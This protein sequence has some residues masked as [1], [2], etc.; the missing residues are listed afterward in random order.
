MYPLKYHLH[1][2]MIDDL[3]HAAI[4]E[5]NTC[6]DLSKLDGIHRYYKFEF[7]SIENHI[8]LCD[9]VVKCDELLD[10]IKNY[11][12]EINHMVLTLKRW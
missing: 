9:N 8:K 12:N 5:I 11:R 4:N 1:K 10:M 7:E 2:R 3:L 6:D